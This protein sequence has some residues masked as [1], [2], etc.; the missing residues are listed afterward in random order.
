MMCNKQSF[1]RKRKTGLIAHRGAHMKAPENSLEAIHD[2]GIL[3]YEMVELDVQLTSDEVFVLMHD[4][5]V[6]RTTTGKGAVQD[7]SFAELKQL[8]FKTNHAENDEEKSS[9][10]PTLEE[11]CQE[12]AKWGLGINVDCSKIKWTEKSMI[13]IVEMLKK[14][15]LWSKSFFVQ[16]EQAARLKLTKLYS[17]A[18][19]T[20]LTN[21]VD[22]T[23]N[24]R[25][26]YKYNN[27]FVTYSSKHVTDELVVVYRQ[28]GIPLF[29]YQCDTV[30]DMKR[31]IARGVRFIETDTIYPKQLR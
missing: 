30:A 28:E 2:A 1:I 17:D 9:R 10:V 7:Y 25:E 15:R 19:V 18:N 11:A 16:A 22:P 27:A 12:C 14:Y 21:D 5:T 24:I 31:N 23:D 8:R 6:D 20:W 26:C 29:I 4:K 13:E 3:G